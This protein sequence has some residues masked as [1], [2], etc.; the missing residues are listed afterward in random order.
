[1]LWE[2]FESLHMK[3]S[4]LIFYYLTRVVTVSSELE[5]NSEEIKR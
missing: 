3:V 2:E 1:M 4:E 5:E